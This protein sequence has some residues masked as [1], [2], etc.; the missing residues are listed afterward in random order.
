MVKIAKLQQKMAEAVIDL[1][2]KVE[3]D[4][5]TSTKCAFCGKETHFTRMSMVTFQDICEACREAEDYIYGDTTIRTVQPNS[6]G[7]GGE[8][9]SARLLE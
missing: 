8:K 5:A 9:I 6:T 2:N 7:R 1:I 3:A 4:M